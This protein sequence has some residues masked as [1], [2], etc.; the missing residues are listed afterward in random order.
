MKLEHPKLVDLLQM[1]Y[2]AERAA[3]FAYIGHQA[4]LKDPIDKAAI[5]QIEEDEW[6]HRK[7]VLAIMKTYNIP[8]S[9]YY[10]FKFYIIGKFIAFS[11]HVIGWFMPF[12]FA[13]RLESGNVCEYFVMMHYFEELDIHDH[14]Q[15]LYE[16]AIKEKEHEDYFL[17]RIK[18]SK[19]LPV[20]EKVFGWGPSKSFNDVDMKELKPL[21]GSGKY[22]KKH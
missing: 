5:K 22:C 9:K 7:C 10:E 6:H 13:G 4:A 3:S 19:W 8:I 20:F 14:D 11:C 17:E 15:I 21:D 1:A 16:M 2:S 18:N 12:F